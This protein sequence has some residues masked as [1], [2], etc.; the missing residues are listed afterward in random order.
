MN[1]FGINLFAIPWLGVQFASPGAELIKLG[2]LS[3][4]W[5]GLL[6]A[7]A[8]ILGTL[9]AQKLAPKRQVDPDIFGDLL[10]LSINRD[11]S[12]AFARRQGFCGTIDGVRDSCCSFVLCGV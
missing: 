11:F 6:I 8:I 12:S 10:H 3:I 4:R 2:P 7:T 9:L 1:A 5:Y